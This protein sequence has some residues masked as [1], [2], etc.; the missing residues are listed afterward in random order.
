MDQQKCLYRH[1]N[2]LRGFFGMAVAVGL[3]QAFSVGKVQAQVLAPFSDS[4]ENYSVGDNPTGWTIEPTVSIQLNSG[5]SGGFP[6]PPP[7]GGL[8]PNEKVAYQNRPDLGGYN[9]FRQFA[10][11]GGLTTGTYVASFQIYAEAANAVT[12]FRVASWAGLGSSAAWLQFDTTTA[13][14]RVRILTNGGYINWGVAGDFTT[15]KWY[16]FK[17]TINMD[18]KNVTY[19]G[20]NLTDSIN[21]TTQT[22]LAF[23]QATTEIGRFAYSGDGGT[24]PNRYYIND[25]SVVPEPHAVGLILVGGLLLAS[26][27][28]KRPGLDS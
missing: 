27:R 3:L 11:G 18:A 8:T 4:W 6:P 17:T 14:N 25:A 22:N 1:N 16:E 9:F 23:A 20:R 10:T 5:T 2:I 21:F 12:L 15:G 26:L 24:N 28:R 13:V 7:V 19:E